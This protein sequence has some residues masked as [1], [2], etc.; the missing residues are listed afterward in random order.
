MNDKRNNKICEAA[1]SQNFKETDGLCSYQQLLEVCVDLTISSVL[2]RHSVFQR[3][4]SVMGRRNVLMAVMRQ[5]VVRCF[6]F[7]SLK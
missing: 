7:F 3:D 5:T 1:C 2:I 6:K 4:G